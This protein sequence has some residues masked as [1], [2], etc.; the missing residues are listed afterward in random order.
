M[1]N[2]KN[3]RLAISVAEAS[4]VLGVSRNLMYKMVHEG[5]IPSIRLGERRI[6][7]P[8]ATLDQYLREKVIPLVN[9]DN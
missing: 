5:I 3:E 1:R 2:Q 7:I 8:L 6:V 9:L 4:E